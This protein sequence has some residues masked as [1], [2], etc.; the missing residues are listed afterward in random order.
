RDRHDPSRA[1]NADR[2]R[3]QPLLAPNLARRTAF[4]IDE[5]HQLQDPFDDPQDH[6][7][8]ALLFVHLAPT[9]FAVH[10]YL[11]RTD[12]QVLAPRHHATAVSPAACSLSR[13]LAFRRGPGPTNTS[14]S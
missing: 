12:Q 8:T 2:R 7:E 4:E 3:P 5:R 6:E 1:D 9:L 11:L 13:R 14:G 10:Y